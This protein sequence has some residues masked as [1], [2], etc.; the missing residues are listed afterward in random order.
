MRFEIHNC[1][2]VYDVNYS[3]Q[4]SDALKRLGNHKV[5]M[6]ELFFLCPSLPPPVSLTFESLVVMFQFGI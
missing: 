5:Y 1:T 4:R 2:E 6:L 3:D